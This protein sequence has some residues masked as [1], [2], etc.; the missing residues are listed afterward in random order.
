M[1]LQLH[2][3]LLGHNLLLLTQGA[4]LVI[5]KA[6]APG[7][8]DGRF[9]LA[10]KMPLL[11][12]CPRQWQAIIFKAWNEMNMQMENGLRRILPLAELRVVVKIHGV[13]KPLLK[14]FYA[15]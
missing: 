11:L 2:L 6:L 7:I 10:A 1:L 12:P 13:R 3:L 15:F 9:A 5:R 4:Y 8:L 14:M